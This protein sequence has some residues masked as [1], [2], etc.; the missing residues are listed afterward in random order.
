MNTD[1]PFSALEIGKHTRDTRQLM[2]DRIAG[3]VC[4]E[5]QVPYEMDRKETKNGRLELKLIAFFF[6]F[7][8]E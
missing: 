5:I 4:V 8:D 2:M 7:N 1:V 6:Y 3:C